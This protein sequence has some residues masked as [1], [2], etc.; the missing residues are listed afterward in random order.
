MVCGL[1]SFSLNF[2]DFNSL[3]LGFLGRGG[4]NMLLQVV[5]AIDIGFI[6][7]CSNRNN[8][9]PKN[10]A[11]SDD[12]HLFMLHFLAMVHFWFKDQ[13]ECAVS[14]FNSTSSIPESETQLVTLFPVYNNTVDAIVSEMTSSIKHE[15][16]TSNSSAVSESHSSTIAR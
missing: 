5:F 2:I 13:V 4:G 12:V 1:G 15:L 7:K 11:F 6:H 10:I 3:F 9:S 8:V 16:N 14:F